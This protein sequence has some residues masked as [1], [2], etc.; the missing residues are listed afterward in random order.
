MN[1]LKMYIVNFWYF[2]NIYLIKLCQIIICATNALKAW[3]RFIDLR[4]FSYNNTIKTCRKINT[5]KDMQHTLYELFY[6]GT[7]DE[8]W[9]RHDGVNIKAATQIY[10]MR[11]WQNYVLSRISDKKGISKTTLFKKLWVLTFYGQ[12]SLSMDLH[13]LPTPN[14]C[15]NWSW[16]DWYYV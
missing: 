6:C 3:I 11:A 2:N 1:K 14:R 5:M 7:N 10:V 16:S 4:A 15:A 8:V 13:T 12:R 9:Q